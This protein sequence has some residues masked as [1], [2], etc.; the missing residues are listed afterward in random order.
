MKTSLLFI[1]S[2]AEAAF[3]GAILECTGT[4]ACN[5]DN[6]LRAVRATAA[7]RLPQASSDC[8]SFLKA[9]VTPAT[10][11]STASTTTTTTVVSTVTQ[12]QTTYSIIGDGSQVTAR[13]ALP[14]PSIEARINSP[15]APQ[16]GRR[17]DVK[18]PSPNKESPVTLAAR[19]ATVVPSSVPTYASA[20]SGTVRYSSACSCIGVTA[21]TST[22]PAPTT[23]VTTTF[24]STASST[25]TVQTTTTL[26][27]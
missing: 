3:G 15:N 25:T 11:T 2:T 26:G 19:Q 16:L 7:T 22:A 6:C 21:T 20:C 17:D 24:V 23:T 18:I 10:V 4:T 5:A 13:D 27:G 8:S 9:T 12:T 14:E 1:L